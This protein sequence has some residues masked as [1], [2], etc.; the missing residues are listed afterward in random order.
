MDG[1]ILIKQKVTATVTPQQ[2]H[3]PVVQK[4]PTPRRNYE[5]LSAKKTVNTV[6]LETKGICNELMSLNVLLLSTI[7]TM[8]C[9]ALAYFGDPPYTGGAPCLTSCMRP[10]PMCL[11]FEMFKLCL[12]F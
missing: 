3:R 10:G 5:A 4:R 11:Q 9:S 8:L 12:L 6:L 2:S 7:N 1:Q